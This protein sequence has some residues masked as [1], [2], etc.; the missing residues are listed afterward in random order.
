MNQRNLWDD[1]KEGAQEGFEVLK[2]E[3]V[4]LTQEIEKHGKIIKKK[5][6]LSSIQRKVHQGFSL[7]GS[8]LYELFEEGKEKTIVN[9]P[10]IIKIISDIK[11][12]KSDVEAIE[13]EIDK[14]REARGEKAESENDSKDGGTSGGKTSSRSS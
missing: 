3:M 12:Y 13:D 11:G 5:M 10:E 7:L 4:K 8:R 2:E 1:I 9:D 14:I 6:D